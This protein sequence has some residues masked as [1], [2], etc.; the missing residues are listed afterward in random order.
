MAGP[1]CVV[2][3]ADERLV[4]Q[5]AEIAVAAAVRITR[6]DARE[7]GGI[8]ARSPVLWG[9]DAAALAA[10]SEL[11]CDVLVGGEEQAEQLWAMASQL[12]LARVAILPGARR[13]LG[14]Y[15]GLRGMR[16]GHG[17]TLALQATVGGIGA[18][19][20]AFLTAHAGTL[21]GLRSLLVDL[22]PHSSRLWQRICAQRPGGIGWEQ[23]RGSGGAL[24]AHQLL[25][26]LPQVGGTS[27][28]SWERGAFADGIDQQ[29]MAR[30][31]AAARQGFDFLVLDTGRAGHPQ[32]QTIGHFIDRWVTLCDAP[33]A[34][35]GEHVVCGQ[36]GRPRGQEE[37]RCLG[38]FSRSPRIEKAVS[39][40]QLIDAFKSRALRQQLADLRLLPDA[41]HELRSAA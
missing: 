39:R 9:A 24:A 3:S 20:L 11:R 32:A 41:A 27:V 8:D 4:A 37:G 12:P 6:C 14:E 38:G 22:D 21:S 23:L 29:L 2:V 30:L 5:C 10:A 16:A 15:L 25:D 33:G 31:L 7:L 35:A 28:L 19:T 34:A 18:S 36:Y 13:W 26:T 17:H 40:G 1:A